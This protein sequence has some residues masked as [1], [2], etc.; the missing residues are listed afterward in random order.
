[1]TAEITP[2][3]PADFQEFYRWH[4]LTVRVDGVIV[5]IGGYVILPDGTPH[6]FM[7]ATEA[8]CRRYRITL[9]KAVRRFFGELKAAGVQRIIASPDASFKAAERFLHHLGFNQISTIN[10]KAVWQW[11]ASS[12]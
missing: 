3:T 6:A 7:D 8:N 11:A 12:D 1:M 10:G 2:A 5:G 4:A 9:A